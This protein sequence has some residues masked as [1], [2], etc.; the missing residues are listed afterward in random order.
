MNFESLMLEK[1]IKSVVGQVGRCYAANKRVTTPVHI[2]MTGVESKVDVLMSKLLRDYK[3]WKMFDYNTENFVDLVED[4]DKLVYLT[5]DSDNIIENLEVGN[6]YIIGGIVDKNRHKN[7]TLN[8]A[9]ELG[10]KTGQLPISEYVKLSQRKVLAV[11]HVFE[12]LVEYLECKDWK[13][14][15]EKVIPQRKL[16]MG[17]DDQSAKGE[18][19][20]DEADSN[21]A[22][23]EEEEGDDDAKAKTEELDETE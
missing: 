17:V 9:K 4:K 16:D 18:E 20:E 7:L 10:I 5:A 2:K 21:N 1:E 3:N 14:A 12:I 23:T 19:E 8:K 11:N 22:K 13:Q 15:F 6:Y